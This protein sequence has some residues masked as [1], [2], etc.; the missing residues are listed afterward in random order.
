MKVSCQ[1]MRT[2][3]PGVDSGTDKATVMEHAV[4]YLLHL[5]QCLDNRCSCGDPSKD[6]TQVTL[7]RPTNSLYSTEDKTTCDGVS[8]TEAVEYLDED[9][10]DEGP[11]HGNEDAVITGGDAGSQRRP[12]T[13]QGSRPSSKTA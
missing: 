5:R 12:V 6:A 4:N 1:M 9:Q 11:M 13:K 7:T 3:I 10:T 8:V 2:L